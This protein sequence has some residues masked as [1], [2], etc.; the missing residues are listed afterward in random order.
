MY[1]RENLLPR[2]A[3]LKFTFFP[4][5]GNVFVTSACVLEPHLPCRAS[6][7]VLDS[8]RLCLLRT[9]HPFFLPGAFWQGTFPSAS[10]AS[11]EMSLVSES[12][13][14]PSRQPAG[15]SLEW[16]HSGRTPGWFSSPLPH[17]NHLPG[18]LPCTDPCFSVPSQ[19]QPPAAPLPRGAGAAGTVTS[20]F[21]PMPREATLLS[22]P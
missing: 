18:A 12:K 21:P 3:A 22:Q 11:Q 19:L 15:R 20:S 14:V 9:Q 13:F 8:S 16:I 7:G 1:A 2:C 5:F 10:A 17:G 6:E 4:W